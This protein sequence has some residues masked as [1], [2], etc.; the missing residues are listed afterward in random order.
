MHNMLNMARN[1]ID[2]EF[3]VVILDKNKLIKKNTRDFI[4]GKVLFEEFY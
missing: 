3:F 1:Q 2:R 4:K